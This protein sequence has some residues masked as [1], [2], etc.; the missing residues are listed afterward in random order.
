M[1]L[2][3]TGCGMDSY[4]MFLGWGAVFCLFE[5][6]SCLSFSWVTYWLSATRL[7]CGMQTVS[8]MNFQ[9]TVVINEAM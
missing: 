9:E 1:R 4:N 2:I 6:W 7:C 3:K 8:G 5:I